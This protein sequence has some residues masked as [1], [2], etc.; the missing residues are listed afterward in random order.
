MVH[1]NDVYPTVADL[2]YCVPTDDPIRPDWR[3]DRTLRP[4]VGYRVKFGFPRSGDFP[5]AENF[6]TTAH[7]TIRGI[8]MLNL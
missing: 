4:G 7:L 2:Q 6:A 1:E 5:T 8:S 3:S